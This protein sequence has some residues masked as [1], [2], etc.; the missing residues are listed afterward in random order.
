MGNA[1]DYFVSR[2]SYSVFPITIPD[3]GR[4]KR[5][6]I[7]AQIVSGM[8]PVSLEDKRLVLRRNGVRGS[9][10]VFVI[11]A[12]ARSNIF[13]S[14]TLYAA[15][16]ARRTGLR[17]G[18]V[19]VFDA[20]YIETLTIVSG[21]VAS[22]VARAR[23]PTSDS[24]PT[25]RRSP[26]SVSSGAGAILCAMDDAAARS[27]AERAGIVPLSFP[28]GLV[29]VVTE[30]A[31]A[32]FPLAS[33]FVRVA[34]ILSLV[35]ALFL[36]SLAASRVAD[37]AAE[38]AR[39]A[40]TRR[41]ALEREKADS[42]RQ[43]SLRAEYERLVAEYT[44]RVLARPHDPYST[45]SLV[46][47]AIGREPKLRKMEMK[48]SGITVSLVTNYPVPVVAALERNPYLYDLSFQDNETDR[49]KP[50]LFITASV[51]YPKLRETDGN[52]TEKIA[53]VRELLRELSERSEKMPVL[54]SGYFDYLA[55]R[56]AVTDCRLERVESLEE[57]GFVALSFLA[58]GS[59]RS[60][61]RFLKVTCT[62]TAKLSYRSATIEYLR[63]SDSVVL[64][65]VILTEI[66]AKAGEIE[67][68]NDLMQR[69]ARKEPADLLG[70]FYR[71]DAVS[72]NDSASKSP[73]RETTVERAS[74]LRYMGYVRDDKGESLYLRNDRDG[75]TLRVGHSNEGSDGVVRTTGSEIELLMN[76]SRY[77]IER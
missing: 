57:E 16:L 10:L 66:K 54:V 64:T 52:I 74:W 46:H 45:L 32:L 7:A 12:T 59:I 58:K 24:A 22:S 56:A 72:V 51:R 31:Y 29:S 61:L 17:E 47:N 48:G 73:R 9:Y 41:N 53:Y 4:G 13:R 6:E 21:R 20:T 14:S 71:T 26:E 27:I 15:R 39:E 8:Y 1:N 67:T 11:D 18:E 60:I 5:R 33:R 38:A 28:E 63:E 34:G 23:I 40:E 36:A 49:T 76:G 37:R 3:A 77:I 44:L 50:G 68:S 70:L 19:V 35:M 55:S 30:A 69:S 2:L 43:E 25:T 62:G 75:S 42:A 65:G